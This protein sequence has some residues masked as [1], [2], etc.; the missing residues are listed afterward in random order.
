MQ[1]T[2]R[3]N[4]IEYWSRVQSFT[5]RTLHSEKWFLVYCRCH[6]D[7]F[8]SHVDKQPKPANVQ[9]LHVKLNRSGQV[10]Y[11]SLTSLNTIQ[12]IRDNHCKTQCL[13]ARDAASRRQSYRSTV[14]LVYIG[15]AAES[16]RTR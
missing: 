16:A 4:D 12:M 14:T 15:V 13:S 5:C 10:R 1:P 6:P 9:H 3:E 7:A 8:Q 11:L 2:I